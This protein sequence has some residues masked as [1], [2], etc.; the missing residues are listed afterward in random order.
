[1]TDFM[2][3]QEKEKAE[4]RIDDLWLAVTTTCKNLRFA[5]S[6]LEKQVE[7]GFPPSAGLLSDMLRMCRYMG[8]NLDAI[9]N[10]KKTVRVL[11]DT[12]KLME[13]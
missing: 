3:R 2:I 6:A 5:Q 9:E 4:S 13:A 11:S 8:K 12:L 1:M 7:N 10:E